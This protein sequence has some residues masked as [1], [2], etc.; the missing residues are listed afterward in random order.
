MGKRSDGEARRNKTQQ[1]ATR[2]NKTQHVPACCVRVHSRLCTRAHFCINQR[3]CKL[4]PYLFMVLRVHSMLYA[5]CVPACCVRACALVGGGQWRAGAAGRDA[6][7]IQE[8][9]IGHKLGAIRRN[10]RRK[11]HH[12]A[13]TW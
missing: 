2:R 6:T 12:G 9:T 1:D 7:M 13:K 8:G 4:R 3:K 5:L 11:A 10:K